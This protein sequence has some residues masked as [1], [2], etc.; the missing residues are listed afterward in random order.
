MSDLIDATALAV[1]AADV[2][3]AVALGLAVR[4]MVGRGV[5]VA[6]V[7]VL[8][9]AG[10]VD[11]RAVVAAAVEVGAVEVGAVE[12]G[13]ARPPAVVV[14]PLA[15]MREAHA[16]RPIEPRAHK[17]SRAE[18]LSARLPSTSQA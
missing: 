7:V 6:L 8:G 15:V 1:A 4:A 14:G 12:V 16:V 11:G 10:V 13:A 3:V 2:D 5:V 17:Q 9:G 18:T